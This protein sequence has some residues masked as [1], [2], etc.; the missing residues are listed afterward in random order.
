MSVA[1]RVRMKTYVLIV[2]MVAFGAM[3]DVLL[4][5]G[6]RESGGISLGSFGSFV[7]GIVRG[8]HNNL[9]WVGILSLIIFFLCYMLVLSWAD[10]SFVSPASAISYAVVTFLG[11]MLLGEAVNST[12]WL[13]VLVICLGVFLVGH[14]PTRTTGEIE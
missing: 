5:K 7:D 12:R 9:V 2:L 13:G 6:M 4:G 10:Y 11:W 14:T 1:S 3:G 8:F